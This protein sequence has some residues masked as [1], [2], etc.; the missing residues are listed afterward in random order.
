MGRQAPGGSFSP[1]SPACPNRRRTMA[2][3]KDHIVYKL[4]DGTKA[5]GT[6]TAIGVMAKPALIPWS[7]KL[8]L[9]GIKVGEYVDNLADIGTL[10]H[11]MIM[12]YLKKEE[13]DTS[14]YSQSQIDLAEN[15]FLSYLEWAKGYT[16]TPI[17]IETPLVSEEYRFGGT[18]DLLAS[19]NGV[20]TLID[21]KTGKAIYPEHGVQVAA[22][23][24]LALEYGYT[25]SKVLILRIGR[26]ES[27]GFEVKP[28]EN[29]EANWEV[30]THCL[31][32][33][34]LQK[35]L[36]RKKG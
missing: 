29:L 36:R 7:N 14:E 1:I 32:I 33:Y 24:M 8:G 23:Y 35:M 21:F 18:L 31:A 2:L 11:S 5:V 27:E 25:I 19:I 22:Y 4:S 10:A 6:T 34:E 20:N 15:S 16:I 28:V 26:D 3:K 13:L 9:Q 12:A 17:L 30:F